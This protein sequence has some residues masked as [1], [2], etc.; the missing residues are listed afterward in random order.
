MFPGPIL[1]TQYNEKDPRGF[2]EFLRQ[3]G[4]YDAVA[5]AHLAREVCPS[6]R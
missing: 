5:C 4:E 6:A 3:A 2:A 1:T